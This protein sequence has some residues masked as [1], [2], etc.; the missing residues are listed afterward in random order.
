[1]DVPDTKLTKYP[2]ECI[3]S[4]LST[5][6]RISSLISFRLQMRNKVCYRISGDEGSKY[7]YYSVTV[8]LFKEGRPGQSGEPDWNPNEGQVTCHWTQPNPN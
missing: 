4:E 8:A 2:V 1:M 7:I 5:R 6:Y 3:Q